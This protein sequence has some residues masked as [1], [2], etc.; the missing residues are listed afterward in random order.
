M[1]TRLLIL[2]VSLSV[3]V[4]TIVGTLDLTQ[5]PLAD[6]G[7]RERNEGSGWGEMSSNALPPPIAVDLNV[8][9]RDRVYALRDEFVF[10]IRIKNTGQDTIIFPWLPV[11]A[12]PSSGNV[13]ST[14]ARIGLYVSAKDATPRVTTGGF[15]LYG[16]VDDERSLKRINP[17]ESVIIRAAGRWQPSGF[18]GKYIFEAPSDLQTYAN[19]RLRS[20][21]KW[22]AIVSSSPLPIRL[23][24]PK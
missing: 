19:V 16:N 6:R 23:R 4:D 21:G 8:I 17:N 11:R 1:A 5:P 20:G 15:R 13:T 9:D 14:E 24:T 10:E 7:S 22:S 2:L 12:E 18:A 3:Q